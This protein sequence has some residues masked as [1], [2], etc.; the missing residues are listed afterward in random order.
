MHNW[1]FLRSF[2]SPKYLTLSPSL[3]RSAF[4][5]QP[6]AQS[7]MSTAP[8]SQTQSPSMGE[9]LEPR[10]GR[11]ENAISINLNHQKCLVTRAEQR[12]RQLGRNPTLGQ[13]WAQ[14]AAQFQPCFLIQNCLI[15]SIV[16]EHNNLSECPPCQIVRASE[17]KVLAAHCSLCRSSSRHT[18][19]DCAHA[20]SW[21]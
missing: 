21:F 7:S 1:F 10:P 5:S 16:H 15:P 20:I 14:L 18:F 4:S 12:P 19:L 11:Q 2:L 17:V 8:S 9:Q 6:S 13:L 3:L